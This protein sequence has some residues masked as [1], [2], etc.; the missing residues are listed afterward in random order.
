MNFSRVIFLVLVK[1]FISYFPYIINFI[2]TEIKPF[3]IFDDP[4]TNLDQEKTKG[5]LELLHKIA[6]EY[7]VIYYTCHD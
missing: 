7:Q 1:T 6:E 2:I 3:V 4:F 5:G